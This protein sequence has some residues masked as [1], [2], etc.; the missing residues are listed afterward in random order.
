MVRFSL[1]GWD[2]RT[3]AVKNLGNLK[4]VLSGTFGLIAMGVSNLPVKWSVPLGGLV[5]CIS[6]LALDTLDY[7]VTENPK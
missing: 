7:W 6:K 1:E 5:V 4:L 3:W 2:F